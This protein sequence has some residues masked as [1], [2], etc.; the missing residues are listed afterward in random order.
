[1]RDFK[2]HFL[3][4]MVCGISVTSCST[5]E[6]ASVHGLTSGY[7]KIVSPGKVENVYADVSGEKIDFYHQKEV[8]TE[9]DK[10]LSVSFVSGENVLLNPLKFNKQS[11]D[12]DI[13]SILLKYRPPVNDLPQQLTTDIN[14]ALYAGWRH[15]HF[16]ISNETDPLGKQ[17]YN[18]NSFGYDLGFFA[19]PGA[20][21]IY[22]GNTNNQSVNDYSAMIIQAGLA[23]FLE[24]EVASFGIA[25]GIDNLLNQDRKIWIYNNKPWVGFIVGIAIN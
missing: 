9:K 4:A 18:I 2:L 8:I 10:F 12:I 16:R 17:Y 7:Y 21:Q 22:A 14:A 25:V 20:T 15:D 19:G 3:V 13:T 23:G 11:L 5:L 24:S 6:K 1:M